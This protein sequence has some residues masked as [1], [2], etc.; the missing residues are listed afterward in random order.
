MAVNQLI[1]DQI[2]FPP[3]DTNHDLYES[4]VQTKHLAVSNL[5]TADFHLSDSVLVLHLRFSISSSLSR[6]YLSC[7]SL[8]T[9]QRHLIVMRV[10]KKK[11]QICSFEWAKTYSQLKYI[12]FKAALRVAQKK[13]TAS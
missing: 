12:A 4:S 5:V 11:S 9:W 7:F 6:S 13:Q 2:F 10:K 3:P 1:V 8:F